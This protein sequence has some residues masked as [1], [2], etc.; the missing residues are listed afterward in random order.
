VKLIT[1]GEGFVSEQ[2]TGAVA[3]GS[4]CAVTREGHVLCCF[5]AQSALGINDFVPTLAVSRD[6]GMTWSERGPVWPELAEGLAVLSPTQRDTPASQA[7]PVRA[8]SH[9]IRHHARPPGS[10]RIVNAERRLRHEAAQDV[11]SRV[12]A[13]REPT[14]TAPV[15]CSDTKPSPV[16][17]S[18]TG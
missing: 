4:R 2:K 6:G 14:A 18:F 13:Q 16:V 15:F 9:V 11:P 10:A 3:V 1:T 5:M 12:T 8:R 17:I 7:K